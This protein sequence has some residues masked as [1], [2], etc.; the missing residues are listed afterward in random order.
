MAYRLASRENLPTG[1]VTF[2]FTDIVGS[3]P[4][5][6]SHPKLMAEALDV[7]NTALY[8]A[9]EARGG[10][11]FKTVGDAF[12]AAFSTAPQAL[13]AAIAGQRALQDDHGRNP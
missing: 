3:T 5:W 1:T 9:I 7:H 12:Q 2:L 6:E 10:M 4:L 13:Q 11:V 8:S